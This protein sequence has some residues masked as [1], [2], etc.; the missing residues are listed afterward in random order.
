MD[1]VPLLISSWRCSPQLCFSE[2][3]DTE[4]KPVLACPN[5]SDHVRFACQSQEDVP[6]LHGV[7]CHTPFPQSSPSH[8]SVNYPAL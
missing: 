5:V 3:R 8:R 2:D 6:L 1:L 4:H 7:C